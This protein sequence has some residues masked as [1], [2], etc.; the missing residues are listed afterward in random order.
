MENGGRMEEGEGEWRGGARGV[1]RAHMGGCAASL[2]PLG[3]VS[4]GSPAKAVFLFF[5]SIYACCANL[6]ITCV[7]SQ[8]RHTFYQRERPAGHASSACSCRGSAC[9]CRGSVQTHCQ[10]RVFCHRSWRAMPSPCKGK[11]SPPSPFILRR[12]RARRAHANNGCLV[13]R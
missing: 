5:F 10:A 6:H 1:A 7:N 13:S 9:S 11:R 12:V 3:G 2:S 4:H 8:H